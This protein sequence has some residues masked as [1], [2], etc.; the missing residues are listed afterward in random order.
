MLFNNN[1]HSN[2]KVSHLL[3]DLIIINNNHYQV[4]VN[5]S[6]DNKY[7]LILIKL[8]KHQHL[9]NKKVQQ[10]VELEQLT[11]LLHQLILHNNLNNKFSNQ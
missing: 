1:N 8:V 2:Q 11:L 5:N 9:L 6:K 7:N 4:R 3:L 10:E